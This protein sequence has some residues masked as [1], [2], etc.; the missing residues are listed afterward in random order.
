MME[1]L[2]D[3]DSPPSD[4]GHRA[5]TATSAADL[6][7]DGSDNGED[8]LRSC[9]VMATGAYGSPITPVVSDAAEGPLKAGNA[10]SSYATSTPTPTSRKVNN[11]RMNP[12]SPGTQLA[13]A[14][15]AAQPAPV[16]AHRPAPA[17]LELPGLQ[18]ATL[19]RNVVRIT[20]GSVRAS[21]QVKANFIISHA[22][23]AAAGVVEAVHKELSRGN[24]ASQIELRQ[25]GQGSYLRIAAPAR[26]IAEL[27]GVTQ[28][29]AED[30]ISDE[31][32]QQPGIFQEPPTGVES[33]FQVVL[34][35]NAPKGG[36]RPM[37][38]QTKDSVDGL[39]FP[40]D[41]QEYST[42][43][44][45]SVYWGLKKAGRLPLSLTLRVRLGHFMFQRYPRGKEAYGYNDFHAM[46][47]NPRASGRL[48]TRIGDEALARRVLDFTRNGVG[49]P[50][51]PT[52]NQTES[53]ADVLPT[54]AFEARS[55]RAKFSIPVKKRTG[56]N[57]RGG[58]ACHLYRVTAQ[59]ADANFAELDIVNLSVGKHL[60]W[61]LE[62][63]N[64]ER[65][66]KTF[67]DVVQYLRSA[68]AELRNSN[69]PHDLDVYPRMQFEPHI[70][71]DK[72]KD[73]AVKTMY[74]FRWKASSYVVQIAINHQ[75]DNIA[76]IRASKTPTVDFDISIFGEYW[77]SEDDAA[78]NIWGDELQLLLE[79][80]DG[81]TTAKGIDR[82]GNFIHTVRDVRDAFEHLF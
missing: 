2:I 20:H 1:T 7:L 18:P 64:E 29:V 71:S 34:D 40:E 36:V 68:K 62:A 53:A 11:M 16:T 26:N 5:H 35:I 10:G 55:Q 46:V 80:K 67:P 47:K 50:F 75:W 9:P 60:D 38:Q 48:E 28:D 41:F 24:S 51:L 19:I 27:I 15:T 43:L 25:T 63:V 65:G 77:D 49:S 13:G 52:G 61:K 22:P 66:A 54:Y 30:L 44:E 23:D 4:N 31:P 72:L 33:A 39:K 17:P 37:L 81:S 57:A 32:I 14:E 45:T 8:A 56:A 78:G 69:R 82:V 74:N 70:T 58:D 59:G 21:K 76:A 79:S 3:I 12:N 73:V 42:R 6:L